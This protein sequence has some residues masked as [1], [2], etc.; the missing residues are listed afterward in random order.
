MGGAQV[1]AGYARLI[2][3]QG[4]RKPVLTRVWMGWG[5]TGF[6]TRTW[7]GPWLDQP[8]RTMAGIEG[9]FTI[10]QVNFALGALRGIGDDEDDGGW[11][12]VGGLGWGF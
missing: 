2:G 12:I 7:N 3:Q 1:G 4:I 5:V 8:A 6:I 9:E 10:A 11:V